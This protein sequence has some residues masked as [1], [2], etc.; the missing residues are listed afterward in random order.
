[1]VTTRWRP[2]GD[3]VVMVRDAPSYAKVAFL[4]LMVVVSDCDTSVTPSAAV[5]DV[6]DLATV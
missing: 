1:M 5:E 2:P 6:L 4:P 3:V